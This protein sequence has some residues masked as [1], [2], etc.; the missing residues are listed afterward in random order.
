MARICPTGG[1]EEV[2]KLGSFVV[3]GRGGLPP[4]PGEPLA[5]DSVSADLVTLESEQANNRN[6]QLSS[7]NSVPNRIIEAQGWYVGE[8]GKIIL[9]AESNSQRNL[10]ISTNCPAY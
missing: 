3:T 4:N 10:Q 7:Q 1:R 5:D 9:T 8:N 2:A 6:S